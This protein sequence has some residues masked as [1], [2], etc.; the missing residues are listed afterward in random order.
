MFICLF[1]LY[2]HAACLQKY[3]GD[4]VFC[5]NSVFSIFP[6]IWTFNPFM[7]KVITDMVPNYFIILLFVFYLA[8]LDFCFYFLLFFLSFG[9][10]FIHYPFYICWSFK[11]LWTI[12]IILSVQF[13]GVR[14]IHSVGQNGFHL[15][16]QTLH[17]LNKFLFSPPPAPGSWH[18]T[19]WTHEVGYCWYY[20]SGI[21]C[22]L[23]F[24]N[25]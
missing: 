15:V 16:K 1:H 20:L 3:Q 6:V 8:Y 13:T 21:L 5:L 14:Y 22:S 11:K 7:F 24:L 12:I 2:F 23:P 19:F 10:V 9:Q 25:W 17:P 18:H 4:W